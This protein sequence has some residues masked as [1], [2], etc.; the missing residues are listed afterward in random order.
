MYCSSGRARSPVVHDRL[1]SQKLLFSQICHAKYIENNILRQYFFSSKHK[2]INHLTPC[3]VNDLYL[4][5][6]CEWLVSILAFLFFSYVVLQ[7]KRDMTWSRTVSHM[8]VIVNFEFFFHCKSV[9]YLKCYIL[10]Q[11]PSKSNIWLQTY[12]RS[13]KFENN[14]KHNIRICHLFQPVTQNQ[15]SRHPTHS[16][17]SYQ[18]CL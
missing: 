2:F 15:Y 8:S 18:I 4:N 10:I 1:F 14:V 9:G 16:S 13:F 3:S 6:T 7:K 12:E 5:S 11:I 17:W